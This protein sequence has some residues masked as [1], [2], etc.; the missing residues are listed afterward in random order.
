MQDTNHDMELELATPRVQPHRATRCA[1]FPWLQPGKSGP[2]ECPTSRLF[3][4]RRFPLF[5][6]APLQFRLHPGGFR[7]RR[8][9]IWPQNFMKLRL[10]TALTDG[11]SSCCEG[12]P[13][14]KDS[15]FGPSAFLSNQNWGISHYPWPLLVHLVGKEQPK[16][17]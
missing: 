11:P 15:L 1:I 10:W 7:P 13:G 12:F 2:R 6:T 16:A 4:G 8:I 3:M 14:F 17:A 5:F 9:R